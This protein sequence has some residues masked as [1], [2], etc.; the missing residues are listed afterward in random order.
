MTGRPA[1]AML[2]P[3]WSAQLVLPRPCGPAIRMSSP[4]R[5]P[6]VR[7]WSSGSNPVGHRRGV[8][9]LVEAALGTLEYVA[10]RLH[11][12]IHGTMA[13]EWG[14][15]CGWNALKPPGWVT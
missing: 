14:H 9:A 1:A 11:L 4:A 13:A 6:P 7:W 5:K 2:R 15:P 8:G 12:E 3:T 10:Q